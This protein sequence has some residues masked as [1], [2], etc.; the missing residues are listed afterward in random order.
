MSCECGAPDDIRAEVANW[1]PGS[2]E[3]MVVIHT[4]Y[5]TRQEDGETEEWG[6]W[7]YE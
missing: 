2:M 7:H 6:F 4:W 1:A 5:I 3:G